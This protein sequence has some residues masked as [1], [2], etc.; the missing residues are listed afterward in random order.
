MIKMIS[1]GIAILNRGAIARN[2]LQGTLMTS[3]LSIN[4]YNSYKGKTLKSI[5]IIPRKIICVVMT[6]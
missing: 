2:M 4:F 3:S 5:C 1:R 6:S